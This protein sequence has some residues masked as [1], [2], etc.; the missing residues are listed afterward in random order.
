MLRKVAR[1]VL[2]LSLRKTLKKISSP[3]PDSNSPQEKEAPYRCRHSYTIVSAVYNMQNYLDDYFES[4]FSQTCGTDHIKIVLVDDGSTDDSAAVI[5]SWQKRYPGKI[6]YIRQE[7]AGPGAA[8]NRG[9]EMV[10]TEWVTFIDT[11]DKIAANYFEEV[12]KA[13]CSHPSLVLATCKLIYWHME[14]DRLQED[15]LMMRHFGKKSQF[16]AVGDEQMHPIFFMNASFFRTDIIRSNQLVIDEELRPIFEDGK[17]VAHYLLRCKSGLVGYLSAPH[18]FYRKRDD[19]SSLIDRSWLDPRRYTLVPSRGYL[20]IL[21]TSQLLK[22]RV[23]LNI[24][25]TVL[26]DISWYF[27]RLNNHPEHEAL[28][29]GQQNID[30]L[31]NYLREILSFIDE[32]ELF[33]ISGSFIPFVTKNGIART[34]LQ[35][36]PPFQLCKLI[37]ANPKRQ[38][39]LIE[40]YT[41]DIEFLLDGAPVAPLDQKRV[42][43][44]FCGMHLCERF[45][46]WISY[47]S[48]SQILSYRLPS[49][50]LVRLDVDGKTYPRSMSVEEL[51][52]R[53]TRNWKEYQ[54]QGDTWIIMDRDTQAD[55]NGEHFYRYLMNNHPEQKALFALRRTS[56]DWDRLQKE[57]FNLVEFGSPEHERA[58]KACSKIISSHADDYVRSYFGDNFFHSKDY[59]F[60]QH[61]I[62]KDDLSGW[63]NSFSP[64]LMLTSTEA[65]RESII[66]DGSPYLYTSKQVALTG[67]PRHDS[68]I[69]KR[70]EYQRC[71]RRRT[72]L[73]MPTWRRYLSGAQQGRSNN[74]NMKAG[75]E[76]SEYATA[77]RS[78]LESSR[79]ASIAEQHNLDIVF[80]PHANVLPYFS[81]GVISLPG[82]VELGSCEIKS[83]QDYYS[84]AALCITDYSSASFEASIAR[85]PVIYYQFDQPRFYGGDHG[86]ASGYFSFERNGFGPVVTGEQECFK[87]IET[88]IDNGFSPDDIYLQ[89]IDSTFR[90]TDGHCCERVYDAI[91]EHCE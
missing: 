11:D 1:K 15:N 46:T 53:Y 43:I 14:D 10:S 63:L 62:I 2:P 8:R 79:L 38:E 22:G 89:R 58:L 76:Q 37:R 41:Q 67:L 64:N 36:E 57:G 60:L 70:Q 12:D 39:L 44:N 78:L 23:P 40:S 35:A 90:H 24:Q 30:S 69:A 87:A 27:K 84:E 5:E 72:L 59:I 17:F 4:I 49:G 85:I 81:T 55:D 65:E 32:E 6:S 48:E 42:D 29:G 74:R 66:E 71:P 33:R 52:Q 20:D 86:I 16:F 3:H 68:L 28:I 7:N 45:E 51:L 82:H 91:I 77:W 19:H 50:K 75:F 9:L 21:K 13:V 34:F 80:F 18:Y 83:I 47:S 31:I 56:A 54:Q 88:I 26:Q 25:Q 61:G 73:I